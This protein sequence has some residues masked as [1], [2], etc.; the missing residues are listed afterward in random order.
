[1]ETDKEGS[2][3]P[4]KHVEHKMQNQ[5][6]KK[7]N[8]DDMGRSRQKEQHGKE[9]QDIQLRDGHCGSFIPVFLHRV[10]GNLGLQH[11]PVWFYT[12]DTLMRFGNMIILIFKAK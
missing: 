2:P 5:S 10:C 12:T 8:P 9:A 3:L 11:V 6:L 1:M 7:R 4:V